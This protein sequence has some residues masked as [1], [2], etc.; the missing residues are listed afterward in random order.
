MRFNPPAEGLLPD[1]NVVWARKQGMGPWIIFFLI[2]LVG[3]SMLICFAFA[4][5]GT[6]LGMLATM[7]VL[8][9]LFFLSHAFANTV[10]TKYFLTNKRI[11]QTRGGVI[12]KE[13]L[14]SR[15]EDKP[16]T[17][18]LATRMEF[19][20]NGDL[21]YG[22]RIFDPVSAEVLIDFKDLDKNSA[23]AFEKIG[24]EVRC[25]YCDTKNSAL[26]EKCSHCGAPL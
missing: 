24:N 13:V 7:L 8:V 26:N 18:F 15:F 6:I 2:F 20:G 12:V 17:Q 1:E 14:L 4:F 16:L 9:G 3:G 25:R 19:I 11:I 10:R 23:E 21:R 22:I 5:S